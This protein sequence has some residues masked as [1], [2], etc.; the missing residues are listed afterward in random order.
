MK[1]YRFNHE[2]SG[3]PRVSKY[4]AKIIQT[5]V[6]GVQ[7]PAAST[8][9]VKEGEKATNK[10]NKLNIRDRDGQINVPEKQKGT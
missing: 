9:K 4:K 8:K 3:S 2:Y 10:Q 5:P 7:C 6:D 1:E